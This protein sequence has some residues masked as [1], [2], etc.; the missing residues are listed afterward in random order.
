[1]FSIACSNTLWI[2][3]GI[4]PFCILFWYISLIVFIMLYMIHILMYL[5]DT[6]GQSFIVTITFVNRN[7]IVLTLHVENVN[8]GIYIL[9]FVCIKKF[10]FDHLMALGP[11]IAKNVYFLTSKEDC[12]NSFIVFFMVWCLES[13]KVYRRGR[14]FLRLRWINCICNKWEV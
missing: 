6:I 9:N 7:I 14:E 1:M 11:Q 10:F 12:L 8:T 2:F 4:Q 3:T 5:G 13:F